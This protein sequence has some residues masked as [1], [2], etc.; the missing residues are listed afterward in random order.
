MRLGAYPCVLEDG[1]LARRTYKQ[2]KIAERHRHRYEF[3]NAYREKLEAGGLVLSGVSPDNGLVEIVELKNHPWFLGCQFHPEFKSRP[4]DP[5]P[6]FKGFIKAAL[7]QR[8]RR[9]EA[10]LLGGLKVVKR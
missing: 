6:L 4:M 5:H 3:N 7:E 10:P 1:T 8:S 2:K 9:S